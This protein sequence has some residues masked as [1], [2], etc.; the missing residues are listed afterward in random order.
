MRSARPVYLCI[1]RC[2]TVIMLLAFTALVTG[3]TKLQ[4]Y[5]RGDPFQHGPGGAPD[6]LHEPVI[7]AA[8]VPAAC[9]TWGPG[10][11]Q[12][13]NGKFGPQKFSL[14]YIEFDDSGELWSIGDERDYKAGDIP[15]PDSQLERAVNLVKGKKE[16]AIKEHR[17]LIVLTFVHGWQNNASPEQETGNHNLRRFKDSLEFIAETNNPKFTSDHTV[18]GEPP[19][20][21]GIFFAWRGLSNPIPGVNVFTY[22]NRRGVAN[23]VGGPSMTEAITELSLATKGSPYEYEPSER[24]NPVPQGRANAN[25]FIIV[26]HSFG[27]RALEHGVTQSMLALLLERKARAINCVYRWKLAN[28]HAQAPEVT[29]VPPAD[30]IVLLNPANDALEA[31]SMIE[32]FKREGL[33]DSEVTHPLIVSIKSDG[34]WAT[35]KAMKVGQFLGASRPARRYYDK[36]PPPAPSACEQGQ[37]GLRDQRFYYDRSPG[38]ISNMATHQMVRT[39]DF[40]NNDDPR[41]GTQPA[42]EANNNHDDKSEQFVWGNVTITSNGPSGGQCFRLKTAEKILEENAGHYD[43]KKPESQFYS[44][45]P[46]LYHGDQPGYPTAGKP[47]EPIPVWND[48]SYYVMHTPSEFIRGH[49]DIFQIGVW[50]LISMMLPDV[51]DTPVE[52]KETPST[53]PTLTNPKPASQSP[54]VRPTQTAQPSSPK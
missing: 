44:C 20:V 15:Y 47:D 34:D 9:T 28:P 21:V 52:I 6:L 29:I 3:C 22:W 12:R 2:V 54:A 37:L 38:G 46:V 33:D 27:G 24:C 50:N 11:V 36:A 42:C 25:R 23:K 5:R 19:I 10:C 26:G 17:Q 4:A 35:G 13:P 7:D 32:A 16:E 39:L 1:V 53:M 31:K 51:T 40:A 8:N 49:N 30:L 41:F 45:S 43:A 14:A 48:T 18:K